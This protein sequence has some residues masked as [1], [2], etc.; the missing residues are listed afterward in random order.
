M[1][2]AKAARLAYGAALSPA[3]GLLAPRL[4]SVHRRLAAPLIAGPYRGKLLD[5]IQREVYRLE[6]GEVSDE[7]F[8]RSVT[9]SM[10]TSVEHGE[11]DEWLNRKV[12]PT[13]KIDVV[14]SDCINYS[15]L[16]R[17]YLKLHF[18]PEG[19]VHGLHGHR[20]VISTQLIVRGKLHVQELDLIGSL[21]ESP[22]QLK[23]R[24]DGVV[25]PLEGFVTTNRECN[26]H[27]FYP[28]DGP[29]VRFQF[30]LR[31]Q[32]SMKDRVFPKRGR[33]Y[34]HPRWETLSDD[35]LLADLGSTG[36]PGES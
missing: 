16:K 20:D 1:M 34:V 9:D 7:D 21:K 6:R 19:D 13:Q 10:R 26:I 30:Y 27:G 5:A 22:T 17:W 24:R 11:L 15:P 29:A 28:T 2:L 32:T 36:K 4:P 18:M 31:G 3:L 33:L 25:G 8:I 14:L 12:E 23:L 35:I